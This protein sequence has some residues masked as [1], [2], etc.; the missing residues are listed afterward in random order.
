MNKTYQEYISQIDEKVALI[1]EQAQSYMSANIPQDVIATEIFKSYEY[2]KEAHKSQA[3]LSG[4]P[5]INHPVEAAKILMSLT[6]D[7]QTI[8]ACFLHDVIEDTP[9][10]SEEI[11]Q[12]FG[13]EVLFLC[14]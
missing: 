13:E 12:E 14:E 11:G 9:I 6:P 5:Y 8:Q 10:S 1:V 7:I 2:A 3:R 4:E